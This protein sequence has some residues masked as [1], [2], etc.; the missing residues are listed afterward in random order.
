[1][2][3]RALLFAVFLAL[4][5]TVAR[6]AGACGVSASGA[7]AGICDASEVLDEKAAAARNRIGVSYGYTSTILFFSD[8]L[9]A[10]TVR[11]AVMASFEHPMPKHWTLELGAGSLLGGYLDT[12]VGRATFSPGVLAGV[13]LSHLIIQPTGSSSSSRPAF[14]GSGYARPFVLISFALAG[15]WAQTHLD[16]VTSVYVAFD[17]SA[18]IAA[19]ASIKIARHAITPFIAGRL[20]GGPVFWT[21]EGSTVL[22]TDA[23][24]YSLGPGLAL[25]FEHARVGLTFGASVLGEKNLR[26]GVS[27]SF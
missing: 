24:K 26:A 10:P 9:R 5:A 20:F 16:S 25:S 13:S 23:Y 12:D 14:G 17:I 6:R 21:H 15:V 18:A 11:H 4:I 1:M 19:G 8:D 22:G 2:K 3:V 27:V 7:P